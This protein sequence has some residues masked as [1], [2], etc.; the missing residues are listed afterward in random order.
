MI[1]TWNCSVH[2]YPALPK[3]CKSD[4]LC[5]VLV[6][7][8]SECP[9]R[10]MPWT[11]T[12]LHFRLALLKQNVRGSIY[13]LQEPFI[14]W[15]GLGQKCLK[16][17]TRGQLLFQIRSVVG[18]VWWSHWGEGLSL[19]FQSHCG[20]H[21]GYWGP[22]SRKCSSWLWKGVTETT[23]LPAAP[24]WLFPQS[25]SWV[26]GGPQ[27]SSSPTQWDLFAF[28]SLGHPVTGILLQ[29]LL[30]AFQSSSALASIRPLFSGLYLFSLVWKM[31][32]YLRVFC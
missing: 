16:L 30:F 1:L 19:V 25:I 26:E 32:K 15:I 3:W 10:V 28:C 11:E 17:S 7:S 8:F 24:W 14:P 9:C 6:C 13:W 12:V 23:E 21:C 18:L 31:Y 22:L 4:E 5:F 27:G 29:F 20:S 2:Q